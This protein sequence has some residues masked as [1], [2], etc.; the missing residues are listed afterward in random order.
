[1]LE[2]GR[3]AADAPRVPLWLQLVLALAAGA[4]VGGIIGP[5]ASALGE[6]AL[7][8][9]RLLKLLA[10][11]LAF[12]AIV[13]T[14]VSTRLPLKRALLLLPLSSLNA[15]VAAAIALGVAHA[16]P[17]GRFVDLVA[18]RA[19][20]AAPMPAAPPLLLSI[21]KLLERPLAL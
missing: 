7:L 20:V 9:V 8:F 21:N 19:L 15:V 14:F 2:P 4:A 1:M 13:D 3:S 17:V 10:T 11:P 12:F 18:L 6:L 16:L 5:R